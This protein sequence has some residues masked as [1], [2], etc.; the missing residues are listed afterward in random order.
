M[1]RWRMQV[2]VDGRETYRLVRADTQKAAKQQ[3]QEQVLSCE[4][5]IPNVVWRDGYGYYFQASVKGK[6]FF[7][8]LDTQDQGQ[9]EERARLK[10]KAISDGRWTDLERT[11]AQRS[12]CTLQEVVECFKKIAERTGRPQPATVKAH[13]NSLRR[14][15]DGNLLVSSDVLDGN[16]GVKY[17]ERMLSNCP[18][19]QKDSRRRSIDAV[20]AHV[21]SLISRRMV[22]E[23]RALGLNVPETAWEAFCSRWVCDA[24]R[25]D[26]IRPTA[27]EESRL[28]EA[29]RRLRN[30]DKD[31]WAVWLMSLYLG[32][33][34]REQAFV[35]WSWFRVDQDGRAWLDVV[36]REDEGFRP[37]GWSGSML[38]DK[39]VWDALQICRRADD[40]YVLSGGSYWQRYEVVTERFSTW[41]RDNGWNRREAAHELRK[42]GADE[43]GRLHG[44]AAADVWLRHAP[45]SVG[46]RHYYERRSEVALALHE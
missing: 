38:I 42:L 40:V 18:E 22:Q 15:M 20:R 10:M 32:L 28:R 36:K 37:K 19:I 17:A 8:T 13:I 1:K 24:P 3:C 6:R 12:Y 4:R 44:G 45:R 43:V 41:M 2:L 11:K 34:A 33:R 29:A 23:Y 31:L 7:Q 25:K 16:A 35:R 5:V 46:E 21:K 30:D 26:Y 9:A 27:E 39:T 14:M